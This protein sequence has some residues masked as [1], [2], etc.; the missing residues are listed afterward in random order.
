[1]EMELEVFKAGTWTDS[2]GKVKTYT[3]ADLHAMAALYAARVNDEAPA[4]IGHPRDNGPARAWVRS[5][6]VSGDKLLATFHHVSG[7]FADW[8]RKRYYRYR[9][10]SIT[11]DLKLRHIG[12]VPVPAVTGLSDEGLP[13]AEFSGAYAYSEE[14]EALSSTYD[15]SITPSGRL[16]MKKNKTTGGAPDANEPENEPT[17]NHAEGDGA[18]PAGGAPPAPPAK[19][20]GDAMAPVLEALK[21]IQNS[22]NTILTAIG[23][24][25][26]GANQPAGAPPAQPPAPDQ[27]AALETE[28][29]TLRARVDELE[30]AA[31]EASYEAFLTSPEMRIRAVGETKA[32]ALEALRNAEAAGKGGN[33][34]KPEEHPLERTKAMLR[35]LPEQVTEGEH[36]TGDKAADTPAGDVNEARA[37]GQ[38]MAKATQR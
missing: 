34:S 36:A 12:F 24:P 33:F 18:P 6:R 2:S 27:F 11:S 7:Q 25:A 23:Q 28:R 4:V 37:R 14:E 26:G 17:G 19:P 8:L 20:E 31:R 9:S 15:F 3:V 35:L 13:P 29:D 5:L 16:S 22:L 32:M 21:G 30:S 38:R 10:V 1:M